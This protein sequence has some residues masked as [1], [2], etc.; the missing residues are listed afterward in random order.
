MKFEDTLALNLPDLPFLVVI[1]ITPFEPW[2]PYNADEDAPFNT[3]IL[4]ISS[5]FIKDKASPPSL[6]PALAMS[7]KELLG[8]IAELFNKGIPST[9]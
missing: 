3:L 4:S 7:P 8:W 5:G 1:N 9:T 6:F 2:L